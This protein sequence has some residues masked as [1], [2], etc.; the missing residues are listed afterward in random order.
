MQLRLHQ[1]GLQRRLQWIYGVAASRGL[2]PRAWIYD[3]CVGSIVGRG[4]EAFSE[5]RLLP[6]PYAKL[7]STSCERSPV[8]AGC[9]RERW[10]IKVIM[11]EGAFS[12]AGD[13]DEDELLRMGIGESL[14]PVGTL[15]KVGSNYC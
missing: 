3:L 2:D 12:M 1:R 14:I 4:C 7:N 6:S 8:E 10:I 5:R 13:C 9:I 11:I 15:D